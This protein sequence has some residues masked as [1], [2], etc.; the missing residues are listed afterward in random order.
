MWV[1]PRPYALYESFKRNYSVNDPNGLTPSWI[2]DQGGFKITNSMYLV[3]DLGFNRIGELGAQASDPSKLLAMVNPAL[4][5][6]IELATGTKF[7]SG[8]KMS[9]KPADVSGNGINSMLAPLLQILGMA[10]TDAKGNKIANEKALY[11][12][13]S[14]IPSIGQAERL[15]PSKPG[16]AGNLLSYLGVPV[17]QDSP[18]L[19][20]SALYDQLKQLNDLNTSQG[21]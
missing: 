15:L 13:N 14:L 2:T 5:V 6:P 4:R 18:E 3:P 17:R 16:K 19:Q 10:G 8:Q 21:V 11:A 1:N 9:G 12:L 7:Y 20:R